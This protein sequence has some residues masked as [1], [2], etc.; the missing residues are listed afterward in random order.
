MKK[1]EKP[2]KK[3]V[4]CRHCGS[5]NVSWARDGRKWRLFEGD[6]MHVC[7]VNPLKEPKNSNPPLIG[8]APYDEQD[9]Y[10]EHE[11]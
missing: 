8:L 9:E 6:C 11:E 5:K 3:A 10:F 1:S 7:T 2:P 4:Q